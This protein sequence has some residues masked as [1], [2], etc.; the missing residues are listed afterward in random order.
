MKIALTEFAGTAPK[1]D[2]VMLADDLAQE[3]T[4]VGFEMG[5]LTGALVST[6]PCADFAAIP[7]SV[8]GIAK[9]AS[10]NVRLAFTNAIRGGVYANM[11]SPSDTWGRVYFLAYNFTTALFRPFFTTKDH[12]T[13]GGLTVDPTRYALGVPAPVAPALITNVSID[14]TALETAAGTEVEVDVQK[15]AYI[16]TI[17]DAYGHEG[18]PSIPTAIVEVSY[19]AP[20]AVDMTIPAQTFTSMNM[21]GG[22]RRFYRAAFDGTTSDWQFIADVPIETLAWTDRLVLGQEGETLVSED[23]VQPPEMNDFTVVNG[24]FLAGCRA[25]EVLYSAYMLPH[26]WPESLRFPL[27]YTVVAIKST[28]GGL[29]I[30]TNGSPFWASG[31]DPS[32]AVPVN[33]GLNLPCLSAASVVDMGGWV[34]YASHDGL[35]SAEAGGATLLSGD[36][37][38]RM[39]WLRDFSPASIKAFGHEGDYYFSVNNS[40]WW[41][42]NATAGRGLRKIALQNIPPSAVR[43]VMYDA[44]RDTTVVLASNGKAYDIVSAQDATLSFRWTSKEFRR[45]PAQ[46]STG[47][48]VSS[49]YPVTL[50]V[51][52]DGAAERYVATSERPFR[53]KAI[54]SKTRWS[55]TVEANALAR[56]SSFA[57]C[58][59][60]SELVNG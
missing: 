57:I 18:P 33:L 52:A 42:F 60:P 3:A 27:P 20:F 1:M 2:R 56:I 30:G 50:T 12:Y 46:F 54:G 26:A 24:S 51:S 13:A 55:L 16:F 58:Q 15:V 47:Q 39:R 48:V 6:A 35:V 22:L 37:V 49:Q 17:V 11:L 23:W 43:Q 59:S 44:A 31:T 19:V 4:N 28:L 10:V 5:L 7:A 40:D 25:N 53:L 9:P 41:V 38:D 21:V 36:Y 32:A 45:S 14:K 29:F 34:I 8:V